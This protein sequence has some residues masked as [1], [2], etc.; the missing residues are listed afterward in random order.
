MRLSYIVQLLPADGW[1]LVVWY[2]QNP[3]AA[4]EPLI[5]WALVEPC[6]Q[7]DESFDDRVLDDDEADILAQGGRLPRQQREVEALVMADGPCLE[8]DLRSDLY[9]MHVLGHCRVAEFATAE[10]AGAVDHARTSRQ[11]EKEMST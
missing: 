6:F 4:C 10:W 11:R 9:D 8:S 3:E 2:P 5:A 7:R 1:G